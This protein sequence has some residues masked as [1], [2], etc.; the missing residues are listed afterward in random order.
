MDDRR[1]KGLG[2]TAESAALEYLLGK[3]LQLIYR[4]F[5]CRLG[6]IDLVML[7]R[8]VLAL[9]EVRYR[10][11]VSFG[12]AAASVAPHKQRRIVQ[13]ARYL[14]TAQPALGRYPAR[15]DVVAIMPGANGPHIDW[16]RAAFDIAQC[17]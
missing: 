1:R 12:G 2:N 14:L 6:E 13:A 16:I 9:I 11:D 4:N 8:R 15:F 3:G 17:R 7:D 10:A 5:R